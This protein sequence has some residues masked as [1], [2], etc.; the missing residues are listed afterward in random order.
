MYKKALFSALVASAMVITTLPSD[1]EAASIRVKCEK[2]ATRSK[3][4]VDGK[5]LV[6]GQY[7]CQAKSGSNQKTTAL[8]SSV[9]DEVECDF[10]SARADI[11]AGATAIAANFIQG[12]QVTGKL[13]D[14]AGFTVASDTVSCRAK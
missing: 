1:A 2:R 9:G 10:D 6:P 7:R 4:S 11:A 13:I 8:V 12:G 5:N 14:A 3:I